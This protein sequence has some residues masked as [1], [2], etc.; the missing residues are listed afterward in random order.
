MCVDCEDAVVC[1]ESESSG[2]CEVCAMVCVECESSGMC[3]L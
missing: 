2:M 1:V 3:G